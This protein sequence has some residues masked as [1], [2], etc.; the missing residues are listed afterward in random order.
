MIQMV[1]ECLADKIE[2]RLDLGLRGLSSEE[3]R[4]FVNSNAFNPLI[5][6]NFIWLSLGSEVDVQ[7]RYLSETGLNVK[8]R[9]IRD[10]IANSSNNRVHT[11]YKKRN[12]FSGEEFSNLLDLG[13]ERKFYD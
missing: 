12:G 7:A 4:V 6:E 10:H 8:E 5:L 9:L 3:R 11:A 2:E 1:R 13:V